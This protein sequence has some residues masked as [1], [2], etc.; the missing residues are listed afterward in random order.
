[1]RNKKAF[2]IENQKSEFLKSI[3]YLREKCGAGLKS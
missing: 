1:M 3:R 2:D